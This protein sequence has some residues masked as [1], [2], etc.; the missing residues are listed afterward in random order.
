MATEMPTPVGALP[1][2]QACD[3]K[4][5]KDKLPISPAQ[6]YKEMK[7]GRLETFLIGNRRFITF[8]NIA[9]YVRDRAAEGAPPKQL[10]LLDSADN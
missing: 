4:G 9:K 7:N 8:E 1:I 2:R 3:P 6:A 10:D 5:G